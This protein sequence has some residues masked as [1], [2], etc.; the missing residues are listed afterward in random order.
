MELSPEERQRIYQE[1]KARI[2]KEEASAASTSKPSTQLPQNVAGFLC[3]LGGWIT[4]IIFLVIEPKNRFVRFHAIQSIATFAPLMIITGLLN[5][6]P[7][8]GDAFSAILGMLGFALWIILM[9]KAYQ[10]EMFKLPLSGDIATS[11]LDGLDKNNQA[12]GNTPDSPS[13]TAESVG[14]VTEPTEEKVKKSKD[15]STGRVGRIVGYSFGIIWNIA[16]LV[17][18]TFFH[19]YI[20]W[21]SVNP[22][23]GFTRYPLLTSDYLLWLPAFIVVSVLTMASY[24]ALIIYDRYWLREITDMVLNILGIIVIAALLIIFPFDFGVILGA[25][26]HV[27]EIAVK[28]TLILIT[29]FMGIAAFV[30]LIRLIV[31]VIKR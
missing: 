30:R 20:A 10:G 9:I 13:T 11:A 31:Y 12:S 14:I 6:V 29:V 19:R 1:E 16:L 17:F 18:L 28:A 27:I 23:G 21:Y 22:G 2:E 8:I 24:V 3:Y 7:I 5:F 25:P 4:G 26:D 15:E